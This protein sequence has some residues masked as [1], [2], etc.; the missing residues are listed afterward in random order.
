MGAV[1]FRE[2]L[3]ASLPALLDSGIHGVSPLGVGEEAD[4][5]RVRTSEGPVFLKVLKDPD[6]AVALAGEWEMSLRAFRGGIRTPGPLRLACSEE[7]AFIGGRPVAAWSW[8]EGEVRED[9]WSSPEAFDAGS[10]LGRIHRLFR[11]TQVS[12]SIDHGK[13]WASISSKDAAEEL[14]GLSASLGA[15]SEGHEVAYA[16]RALRKR[17]CVL[18]KAA[19]WDPLWSEL[20]VQLV[21]GDYSTMNVLVSRGAVASVVDFS[22]PTT[23]LRVYEV[24]RAAFN[25]HSIA[26]RKDWLE[27]AIAF[28]VGYGAVDASVTSEE[29]MLASRA[30]LVQLAR[31]A[32]GLQVGLDASQWSPSLDRF[33]KQRTSALWTLAE[34]L[35]DIDVA[36][37]RAFEQI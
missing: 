5:F 36:V 12:S 30:A 7:L 14:L 10:E 2:E 28:L 6:G 26:T 15:E 32:Y 1:G 19:A 34:S 20:S 4:S 23:H 8:M 24:G 27:S 17:L 9:G 16:H 21:H 22:R 3:E 11:S 31:S 25:T 13:A 18:E 35:D 37:R 29:L 33:W